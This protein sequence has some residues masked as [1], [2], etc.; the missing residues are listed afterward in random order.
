MVQSA[1][2]NEWFGPSLFD[3]WGLP[4]KKLLKTCS[5]DEAEKICI[6]AEK[7]VEALVQKYN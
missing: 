4:K 5:A 1:K 2:E 6:E 7:I 3:I